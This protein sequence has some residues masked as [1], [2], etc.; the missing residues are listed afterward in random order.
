MA[1]A[2]KELLKPKI[3][4]TPERKLYFSKY[5]ITFYFY[6]NLYF[7]VYSIHVHADFMCC[8]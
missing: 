7:Q 5:Y 2:K 6:S 1:D 8:S 3:K 4:I